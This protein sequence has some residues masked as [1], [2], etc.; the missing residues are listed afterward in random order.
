M[1][2]SDESSESASE[3][4]EKRW[5]DIVA[6]RIIEQKGHQNREGKI[7][8]F[9]VDS[10]YTRI[11]NMEIS[12]GRRE[13]RKDEKKK[14]ERL[15]EALEIMKEYYKTMMHVMYK[16][17]EYEKMEMEEASVGDVEYEEDNSDHDDDEDDD[18]E[19]DFMSGE[20]RKRGGG[21]E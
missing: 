6:K 17:A 16:A 10:L 13:A 9:L 2:E 8:D 1:W 12:F 5:V 4:E 3:D 20:V 15:K 19:V 11:Y 7:M 21:K 14:Y 18:M